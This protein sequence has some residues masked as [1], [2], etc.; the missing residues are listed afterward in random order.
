VEAPDIAAKNVVAIAP[1]ITG[2]APPVM[3]LNARAMTF[4]SR[5]MSLVCRAGLDGKWQNQGSDENGQYAF[6]HDACFLHKL[7]HARS[8]PPRLTWHPVP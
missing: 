6:L 3:T 1:E 5:A 4:K 8:S 7:P 2:M